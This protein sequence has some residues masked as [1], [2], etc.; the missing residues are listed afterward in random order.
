MP[1]TRQHC[2]VFIQ[3]KYIPIPT[4]YFNKERLIV[5][6]SSSK[7]IYGHNNSN[8]VVS[9]PNLDVLF[10]FQSFLLKCSEYRS[11]QGRPSNTKI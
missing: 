10:Y 4:H 8:T 7:R 1:F 5:L 3:V 9:G 6:F 2:F 11:N